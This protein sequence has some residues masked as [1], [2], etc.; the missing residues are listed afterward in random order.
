MV[1][2]NGKIFVIEGPDGSGKSTMV[3]NL[4]KKIRKMGLNI[5]RISLPNP[6]SIY[7]AEIRRE[8]LNPFLNIDVLQNLMM[9]NMDYCFSKIISPQIHEGTSFIIDRWAISTIIYSFLKHG[10]IIINDFSTKDGCLDLERIVR[11]A[12]GFIWP[13]KIF[14]LNTPKDLLYKNAIDR[15]GNEI[16][17][18]KEMVDKIYLEYKTFYEAASNK[19]NRYHGY[20]IYEFESSDTK[21]RHILV[22]PAD[23]TSTSNDIYLSMEVKITNMIMKEF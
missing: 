23:P 7:Y 14:Y 5:K 16:F 15:G 8:L 1:H 22:E 2:Q 17:D 18:K 4:T 12:S 21:D 11:V 20:K 13:N 3:A 10:S 6:D 19:K 9:L